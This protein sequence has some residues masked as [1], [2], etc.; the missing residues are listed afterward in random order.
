MGKM[1]EAKILGEAGSTKGPNARGEYDFPYAKVYIESDAPSSS[2][3][4][5]SSSSIAPQ[6]SS[7]GTTAIQGIR[8]MAVGKGT[9]LVFDAQGKFLTSFETENDAA[10]TTAIK[11]RY[12]SGIFLVDR[13]EL[14]SGKPQI[15]SIT[16]K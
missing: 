16:V 11:A 12:H 2:S 1:H 14:L 10:L 15:S 9:S 3:A 4:A 13:D 7:S 8:S 6:S 5:P